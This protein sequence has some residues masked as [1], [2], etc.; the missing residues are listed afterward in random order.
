MSSL[1]VSVPYLI[2]D[3][4]VTDRHWMFNN[5]YVLGISLFHLPIEEWLFF[6]TVPF[7]CLFTWEMI[8]KVVPDSPTGAGNVIRKI[9]LFMPAIGIIVFINGQ[10]YSGLV[11]L[12]LSLAVLLDKVFNTN[13]V[14]QRRFYLYVILIVGFTLIFNG[15]LTWRPV[16]LYDESY[17]LG[18][19]IFT[20]PVEDFGYGTSFLF[21]CTVLFEK[22]KKYLSKA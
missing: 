16:V 6:F 12:F 22:I 20:I 11:L 7:A 10:Q 5:D 17:Q 14:Y 19:R 1:I 13:L 2:W 21:L 18:V 3:A 8:L 9:F 4:L 15:Y